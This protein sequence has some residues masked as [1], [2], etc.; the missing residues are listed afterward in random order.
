M[1]QPI[2]R[3]TVLRAAGVSL[4]LPFLEA[5][6]PRAVAAPSTF[7]P[8]PKSEVVQPRLLCCYIPNGVNILE[9]MPKD[10]GPNYTL[11]P[12]LSVL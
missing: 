1:P 4:A 3:R 10:S 6:R 9:W 12:T 2:T 7:R 11:S 5:M 8:W